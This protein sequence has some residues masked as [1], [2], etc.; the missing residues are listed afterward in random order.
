MAWHPPTICDRLEAVL[1]AR[2]EGARGTRGGVLLQRRRVAT[3]G[4]PAA[5][6]A[7]HPVE[8][9]VDLEVGFEVMTPRHP[10]RLGQSHVECLVGEILLRERDA[11][12]VGEAARAVRRND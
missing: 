9:I 1:Q 8:Q 12:E 4:T 6:V 11:A 3:A 2:L 5:V 10:E 7:V